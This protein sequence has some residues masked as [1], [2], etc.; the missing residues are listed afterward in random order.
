[1]ARFE[2][3]EDIR[4]LASALARLRQAA[5][6]SQAD[7]GQRAGMTSQ[8]W[9]AYESGRRAGLFRPDVQRRLTAAVGVDPETL[10]LEAAGA[11][12]AGPVGAS[13]PFGLEAKG[14]DWDA[15]SSA[16]AQRLTLSDDRLSPWA[17]QGVI[18]EYRFGVEPRPGQGIVAVMADG[19]R[20]VGVLAEPSLS[21]IS[22]RT[23]MTGQ[24]RSLS[25]SDIQRLAA[26][27]ARL[28]P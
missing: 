25:R 17:S 28:D 1:M 7:A 13:P 15:V 20:V 2:S 27:T 24:P 26:V 10:A 21:R 22:V 3:D 6:L 18:L 19:E 9:S 23:S 8:G 5:G 12:P 11:D 4:R 16:S 14:R